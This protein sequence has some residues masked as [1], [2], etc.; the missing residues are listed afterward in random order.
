M[1]AVARLDAEVVREAARDRWL[2]ILASLGI[3]VTPKRHTPCPACGGRD[4]F[5]FDDLD[6]RGTFYCNQ[7]CAGDGFALVMKMRGGDFPEALQIVAGI[8]RLDASA[9]I[10]RAAL[11]RARAGREQARYERERQREAEGRRID[12]LREADYL[13][14]SAQDI[15]ISRWSE[16]RLD[17]AFNELAGAYSLLEE[18]ARPYG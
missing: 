8:L 5:R 9:P 17:A 18:E 10:D 1:I 15:D 13:V 12:R 7:C 16:E 2:F 4:R 11:A 6:G 3:E 14:R